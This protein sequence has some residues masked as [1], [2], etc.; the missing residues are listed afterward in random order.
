MRQKVTPICEN[1]SP[2][3]SLR[4]GNLFRAQ[5]ATLQKTPKYDGV[6]GGKIGTIQFQT[7]TVLLRRTSGALKHAL[8]IC[9][10]NRPHSSI[11]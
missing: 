6:V 11:D 5:A 8:K 4:S 3:Q 7:L 10:L 1:I 2:S 9:A